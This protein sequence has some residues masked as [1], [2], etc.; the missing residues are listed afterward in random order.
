MVM[1][2]DPRA[3]RSP[4]PEWRRSRW[5]DGATWGEK[6]TAIGRLW[7][8][9]AGDGEMP[10][11]QASQV[12]A[13]HEACFHA[14]SEPCFVLA[15]DGAVIDLNRAARAMLESGLLDV[16]RNGQLDFG[17]RA[18]NGRVTTAIECLQDR[19]AEV[20]RIVVLGADRTWR[21]WELHWVESLSPQ[22]FL[23][24]RAEATQKSDA[25]APLIEAFRLTQA[26]AEVL[27]RLMDGAAPKEIGGG[28]G[29]ST[30][31]VRTH[32]RAI[33]AKLQV[34]GIAGALRLASQ[35]IS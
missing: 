13:D 17:S 22:I 35:L 15:R 27:H 6:A 11:P 18:S 31:T 14:D 32:L 8:P 33:Y 4:E 28:M 29:I 10:S 9:G 19:L 30:H 16:N 7:R 20:R 26:Q 34:H 21:S 25:M 1:L 2:D 24:V 12:R 5:S 3:Q 23:T